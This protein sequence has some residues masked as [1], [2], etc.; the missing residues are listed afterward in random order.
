MVSSDGRVRH[1]ILDST[2]NSE[3]YLQ[4]LNEIVLPLMTSNRY[5]QHLFMQDGASVH[6]AVN[7]RKFL[8]EKLAGL[9]GRDLLNGCHEAPI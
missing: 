4:I 6:W 3:R 8:N 5:N 1:K 7:V 9:E 2:M